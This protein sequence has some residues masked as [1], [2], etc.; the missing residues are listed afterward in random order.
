[1]TGPAFTAIAA[2]FPLVLPSAVAHA[3]DETATCTM[4]LKGLWT[5]GDSTDSS[6]SGG[7]QFTKKIAAK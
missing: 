1:M 7:A 4:T 5:V 2:L 6:M 3:Q